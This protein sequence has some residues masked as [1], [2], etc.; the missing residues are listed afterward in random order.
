MIKEQLKANVQANKMG[1]VEKVKNQAEYVKQEKRDQKDFLHIQK[2]QEYLKNSSMKQMIKS[3][4]KEAQEKKQRDQMEKQA[5][6]RQ[7]IEE[8]ALREEQKRLEH[9]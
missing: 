9:E 1:V 2:Q 7:Q 8:K 5:R 3:Q 6:T 4:Q